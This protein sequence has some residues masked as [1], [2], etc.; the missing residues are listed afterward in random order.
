[1][2][3]RAAGAEADGPGDVAAPVQPAT[4]SEIRETR[5]SVLARDMTGDSRPNLK[6][7]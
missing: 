4:S 2:A 5:S 1:V 6:R 3:P 7:T